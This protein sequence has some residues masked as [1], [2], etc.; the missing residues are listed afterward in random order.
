MEEQNTISIVR[1]NYGADAK[2]LRDMANEL[3][4]VLPA[5]E[6]VDSDEADT[7]QE[8]IE[9]MISVAALIEPLKVMVI[10]NGV[11]VAIED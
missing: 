8:A 1:I 2:R 5:L 3:K 9:L 11:I 10:E 7:V 4:L 6:E